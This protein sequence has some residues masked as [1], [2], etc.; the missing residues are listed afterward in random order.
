[1]TED[2]PRAP[3]TTSSFET[4]QTVESR[5]E[6]YRSHYHAGATLGNLQDYHASHIPSRGP[7]SV[8]VH[9]DDAGTK[10]FSHIS[11][12]DSGIA[13][14]YVDGPP[15]EGATPQMVATEYLQHS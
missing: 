8:C 12:G 10:S 11:V 5:R 14:E 7:Y 1:M 9:R 13:F 4:A 2:N 3:I 15:C 6:V